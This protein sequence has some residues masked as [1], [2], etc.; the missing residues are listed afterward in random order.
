MLKAVG[1]SPG[2]NVLS[3]CL[4]ELKPIAKACNLFITSWCSLFTRRF[5]PRLPLSLADADGNES[6]AGEE[7]PGAALDMG[8]TRPCVKQ[9]YRL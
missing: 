3:P 5:N 1:A 6:V 8:D 4:A 7:D 9:R 2:V